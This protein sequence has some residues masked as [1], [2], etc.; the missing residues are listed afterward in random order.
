M[1]GAISLIVAL[2]AASSLNAPAADPPVSG[3]Q[4]QN[5]NTLGANTVANRQWHEARYAQ[6]R[7]AIE[8]ELGK[9]PIPDWAGRYSTSTRYEHQEFLVAPSGLYVK[10][11][12]SDVN[13]RFEYGVAHFFGNQFI[14]RRAPELDNRLGKFVAGPYFVAWSDKR[15]AVAPA[16][17]LEFVNAVNRA[18]DS[19]ALCPYGMGKCVAMIRAEPAAALTAPLPVL[20]A[21]WGG[22]LL[23]API[24]ATVTKQVPYTTTIQDGAR[25]IKTRLVIDKGADAG[26][27]PG[28][29]LY[30]NRER[31][32]GRY[33][34]VSVESVGRD[35]AWV[36]YSDNEPP[37]DPDDGPP[38]VGQVLSTRLAPRHPPR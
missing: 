30:R 37:F 31:G 6:Y 26:L 11:H 1:R 22:Y 9:T 12:A 25:S 5:S 28:M 23:K 4:P 2:A 29:I 14:L 13:A 7:K 19:H 34:H 24:E 38:S 16:D 33:L 8:A 15:Y 3:L 27:R 21:P 10:A 18:E 35:A 36:E 32:F 17:M 20:A